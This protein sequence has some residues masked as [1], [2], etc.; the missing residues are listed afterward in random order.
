MEIRIL[1]THVDQ[2]DALEEYVRHK[3]EHLEHFHKPILSADLEVARDRHHRKGRIYRAEC[4]L[5]VAKKTIYAD[6]TADHPY[7]AVDLCLAELRRELDKYRE[8]YP[9]HSKRRN[10]RDKGRVQ[11]R[12]SRLALRKPR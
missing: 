1:W 10:V 3:V 9:N 4:R 12:V 8:H 11:K 7:E 5:A 2:S 6:A